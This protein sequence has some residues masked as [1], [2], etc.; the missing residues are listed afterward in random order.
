METMISK[1]SIDSHLSSLSESGCST[2]TVR[3]YRADLMGFHGWMTTSGLTISDGTEL[4]KALSAYLT[5][6]RRTLAPRTIT[7]KMT[8]LRGY[9][10]AAGV[11]RPLA[12]YRGPKA[13]KAEPHPLPEG[14]PGVMKMIAATPEKEHRALLALCG[15]CGLRVSEAVSIRP[16]H[17][18]LEKMVLLFTGKGARDREV[19]ISSGAMLYILPCYKSAV[20]EN[21]TLVRLCESAA[22]KAIRRAGDRAGLSRTVASHDLRATFATAVYEKS[23]KD[24]RAVQELLGHASVTTTEGYVG[25]KEKLRFAVEL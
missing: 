18:D 14:I 22:R 17:I 11:E 20:R 15:L 16:A 5:E 6:A 10:K 4:E 9:A 3:A 25:V 7:R 23:G 1:D 19:P 13:T 24:I 2:N 8:A 12:R 21:A